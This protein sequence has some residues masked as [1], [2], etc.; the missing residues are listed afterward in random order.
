MVVVCQ[1]V[2]VN[3]VHLAA[4]CRQ[5]TNNGS[6]MIIRRAA[7]EFIPTVAEVAKTFGDS[8]YRPK[9]LAS[10]ATGIFSPAGRLNKATHEDKSPVRRDSPQCIIHGRM[11][12]LWRREELS[13][14][15]S[16]TTIAWV[17]FSP[18]TFEKRNWHI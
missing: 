10:S 2:V 17:R 1:T 7:G 6:C 12:R 14:F 8:R 4:D 3:E 18:P 13:T 16:A 5:I 11:L 9:L 15:G